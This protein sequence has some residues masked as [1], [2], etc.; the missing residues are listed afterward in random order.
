RGSATAGR[1]ASARRSPGPRSA[2]AAARSRV[3]A[4]AGSDRAARGEPLGQLRRDQPYRVAH[5]VDGVHVVVG[6]LDAELVLEGEDDVDQA[7][8]VDLEVVE[9]VGV[10]TDVGQ[11]V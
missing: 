6:D 4:G 3:A 1:S 5:G 11:R 2:T 10:R 9:D 8:R 7:C